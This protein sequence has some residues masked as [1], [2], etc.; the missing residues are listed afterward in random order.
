MHDGYMNIMRQAVFHFLDSMHHLD[1][2][3]R[4][5][6]QSE[7]VRHHSNRDPTRIRW[8]NGRGIGNFIA[9]FGLDNNHLPAVRITLI[10]QLRH[11]YSKETARH[12]PFTGARQVHVPLIATHKEA[13]PFA[14][15]PTFLAFRQIEMQQS[16]LVS[17]DNGERVARGHELSF[18][19][20]VCNAWC[21]RLSLYHLE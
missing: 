4:F 8:I 2:S 5:G 14:L 10:A 19:L 21:Y 7:E 3:L 13:A 12:A 15:F 11:K 17:N 20:L 9:V 18:W 16:I 1:L 6:L